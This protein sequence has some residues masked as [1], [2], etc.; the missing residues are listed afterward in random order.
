MT[1]NENRSK[2][3]EENAADTI[4]LQTDRQT[5]KGKQFMPYYIIKLISFRTVFLVIIILFKLKHF[6]RDLGQKYV[7]S[8]SHDIP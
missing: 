2:G 4:D 5:D 3:S 1:F 7:Y 6:P 8:L